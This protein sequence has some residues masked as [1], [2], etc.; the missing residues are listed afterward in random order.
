MRVLITGGAGYIGSFAVRAFE[1]AGIRC[2]VVDD[3]STGHFEA[4]PSGCRLHEIDL[5]DTSRVMALL[6]GVR[7][8]AVVHF[9]AKSLVGESVADP[10][11]YYRNNVIG[12]LNLVSAAR[13]A[14]VENF[15]FSSTAAVYGIPTGPLSEDHP[16]LPVNPYGRSKLTVENLLADACRAYGLRCIALRYFNAAGAADDGQLGEDHGPETHLIPLAVKA[17]LGTGD[18]LRLYGTDYP[19]RD[20]TAVRDFIHVED[21]AEAHVEALKYLF[22]QRA[23]YFA[24]F[25]VGTGTGHTVREVISAVEQATARPVPVIEEGRRAGDPHSLVADPSALRST[26]GWAPRSAQISRIVADAVRW[27]RR[28]PSG[29][30]RAPSASAAN[31]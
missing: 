17:A 5:L 6:E 14:G 31:A 24:P 21:L 25:N 4:I 12:T 29:Y 7:F 22:R 10:L 18:P 19:T 26:L 13:A 28:N 3:L 1:R 23:G 15:I 27:H 8:G 16:T 2:E 30:G 9:A 20:G 11:K